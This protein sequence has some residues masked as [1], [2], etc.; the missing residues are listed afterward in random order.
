L[1]INPKAEDSVN[2]I[3][4]MILCNRILGFVNAP[5]LWQRAVAQAQGQSV[6]V[7][8]YKNK[9][10]M[11]C[12]GLAEIGYG[13]RKPEGTFYLF[14]KSPQQ[15]EMRIVEALQ[16]ELILVVPGK[17]FGS[18]GYFRIAFCVEDRVIEGSLPGFRKAF[19]NSNA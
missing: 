4:G 10:D 3:N 8:D 6:N 1:A 5:A 13:F 19:E 14:P 9:R 15:D 11:L 7:A 17:G 18:P 2:L 16:K 12:D